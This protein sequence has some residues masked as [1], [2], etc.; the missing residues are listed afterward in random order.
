MFSG[1]EQAIRVTPSTGLSKEEVDRMVLESKQ[2]ADQDRKVKETA[3]LRNRIRGQASALT[4]SYSEFGWL[5]DADAQEMVK[6]AIQKSKGL[7]SEERGTELLRG[8]LAQLEE[9]AAKL[10]AVMGNIPEVESRGGEEVSEQRKEA[11][12]QQLFKSALKD[13]TSKS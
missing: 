12:V 11:R 3:E 8:L 4:R 13:M 7:P 10:S 5:L 9:G 1:K 2:Y 6:S